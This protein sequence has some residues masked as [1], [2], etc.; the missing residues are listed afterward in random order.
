MS[1]RLFRKVDSLWRVE[2]FFWRYYLPRFLPLDIWLQAR[3]LKRPFGDFRYG[4]TPWSTGQEIL[5]TAG[6]GPEDTLFDLGCGRGKMV[7]LAHLLCG[8]RAVGVDLLASY[9][10]IGEK[11]AARLGLEGVVFEHADFSRVDLSEA[12]AVYIAGSV[13]EKQTRQELMA[14][15]DDLSEGTIW[16]TVTWPSPHPRL[17]LFQQKECSFSWG[18]ET[19]YFYRVGP[20]C[21]RDEPETNALPTAPDR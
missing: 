9:L 13:F 1:W 20:S 8:A 12:T 16:I 6:L 7:F 21:R 3:L 18:R 5:E 19:A 15:V 14:R 2:L 10:L 17:E 4:E 11:I